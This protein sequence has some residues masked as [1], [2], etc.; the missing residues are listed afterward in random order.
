MIGC[1]E[2][3][4]I[5]IKQTSHDYFSYKMSYSIN[6]Q[7]ICNAYGQFTT[8]EIRWS[9]SVHDARVSANC[10]VQKGYSRATT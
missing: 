2:I 4:H 7:A 3:T 6:C 9:S 1:V 10:D 5:P 8:V